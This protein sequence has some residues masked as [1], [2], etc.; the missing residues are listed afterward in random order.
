[1]PFLLLDT[2]HTLSPS[3]KNIPQSISQATDTI[4]EQLDLW[5]KGRQ[6]TPSDI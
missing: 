4:C 5:I 2:V 1:M 6:T 3:L